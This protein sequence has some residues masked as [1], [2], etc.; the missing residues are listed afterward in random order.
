MKA[1][2]EMTNLNKDLANRFGVT[3]FNNGMKRIPAQDAAFLNTCIQGCKC[4]ESTPY[5]KAWLKGWDL[6]N[7]SKI[8]S[9]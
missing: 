8:L 2:K 4:G 1:T 9:N 5:L 3:A 6:A 7:L